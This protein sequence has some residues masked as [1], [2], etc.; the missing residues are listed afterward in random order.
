MPGNGSGKPIGLSARA[1]Q[2]VCAAARGARLRRSPQATRH[3]ILLTAV[4]SFVMFA[5][6]WWIDQ[7]ITVTT[8]RI[9]GDHAAP[10][11][12]HAV[13]AVGLA[14]AV[15]LGSVLLAF[16]RR[17]LNLPILP[18]AEPRADRNHL[19]EGM[20]HE[21]IGKRIHDG[22]AQLLT[23]VMLRLDELDDLL[24]HAEGSTQPTAKQIIQDL[25]SAS[26]DALNDLRQISQQLS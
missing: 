18:A 20:L 19:P 9:T 6:G 1:L 11:R 25:R 26:A 13:V 12:T 16:R 14:W 22:P 24:R 10:G 8:V 2:A 5:L 4:V 15:M 7:Y 23:Y 3:C 21:V 17:D